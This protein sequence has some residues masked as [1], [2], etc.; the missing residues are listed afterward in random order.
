M[1]PMWMLLASPA[2]QLTPTNWEAHLS[3]GKK[4]FVFFQAPW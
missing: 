2:L 3:G 1:L 4:A